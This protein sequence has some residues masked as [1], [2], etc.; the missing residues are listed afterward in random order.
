MKK[1][2]LL[3]GE[4]L[5]YVSAL[6]QYKNQD[7][8]IEAHARV[9]K[10]LGRNI[11][12]VIAGKGT[13][14]DTVYLDRLKSLPAELGTQG[15][16]RFT[17]QLKQ[18]ELRFLYAHASAFIF[19]SS[20][21][22]FGNPIFESWASG[23]PIATSN[24]HSFPEIVGDAGILFDPNAPDDF[25]RALEQILSDQNLRKMLIAKGLQ[26]VEAF[27]WERCVMRTLSLL[28]G[29]RRFV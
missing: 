9:M 21:E 2:D 3:S 4:Y 17:G 13:G 12:L 7:K 25:D 27:T 5:L 1:Y 24:V 28:E 16:V 19:P 29:V 23:I 11:A 6:W 8:L 10:K 26:R 18:D 22:S 20:Y 15:S 14:N